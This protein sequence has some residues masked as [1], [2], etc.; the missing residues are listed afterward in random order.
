MKE[1]LVD[2]LCCPV[3][4]EELKLCVE[5]K[6]DDEIISGS[7]TCVK[8]QNKYSISDGIPDLLPKDTS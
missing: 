6:K 1:D 4:K 2:I 7:L 8:C 3:C 5:Q